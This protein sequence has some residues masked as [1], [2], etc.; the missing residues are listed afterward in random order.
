MAGQYWLGFASIQDAIQKA[1][2]SCISNNGLL[3]EYAYQSLLMQVYDCSKLRLSLVGPEVRPDPYSLPTSMDKKHANVVMSLG[4]QMPGRINALACSKDFTFSAVDND[5]IECRR[6]KRY[7]LGSQE[8]Q[9]II[10]QEEELTLH[11]IA[12]GCAKVCVPQIQENL[13]QDIQ[14]SPMPNAIAGQAYTLRTMAKSFSSWSS[15]IICS[16]LEKTGG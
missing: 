2:S 14:W 12:G 5:I 10:P 3:P 6:L 11:Q 16:A 9:S 15:V 7:G 4:L 13:R 8:S 1:F